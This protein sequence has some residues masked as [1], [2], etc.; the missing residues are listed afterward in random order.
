MKTAK[1]ILILGAR[2]QIIK[3]APLIYMARKNRDMC[4]QIVHTGQ[5]YDYEMSKQFFDELRLLV[6]KIDNLKAYCEKS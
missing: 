1:I 5:H 6:W 2:P 4:I 3:S